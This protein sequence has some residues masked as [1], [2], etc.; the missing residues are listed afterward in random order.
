MVGY[1]FVDAIIPKN[2]GSRLDQFS[3]PY[4]AEEFRSAAIEGFMPLWKED[5]FQDFISDQNTHKQFVNDLVPMPL[6]V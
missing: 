5:Q 4:E 2:N 6:A 3:T 1:I